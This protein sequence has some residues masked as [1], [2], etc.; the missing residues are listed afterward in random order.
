MI[1]DH[2]ETHFEG[3]P[4]SLQQQTELPYLTENLPGIGGRWKERP[5]DFVVEEIPAYEPVDSG[6]HLFLWIEKRDVAGAD[7]AGRRTG[8]VEGHERGTAAQPAAR[9]A[10][11]RWCSLTG[12]GFGCSCS[13]GQ[14]T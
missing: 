2:D 3:E 1:D 11:G 9:H 4:S 8:T 14:Q 10:R 7:H 5:E 6:E 12:S 13:Q